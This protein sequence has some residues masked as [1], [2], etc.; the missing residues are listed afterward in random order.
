[1]TNEQFVSTIGNIVQNGA[2]VYFSAHVVGQRRVFALL[3]TV[4][5]M[6]EG[7]GDDAVQALDD[8]LVK[9]RER[10]FEEGPWS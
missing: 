8:L 5:M 1:M 10:G 4:T 6:F 7:T 3:L 2:Q 9:A